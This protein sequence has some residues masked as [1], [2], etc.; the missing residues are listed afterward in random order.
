MSAKSKGFRS[1]Q[2]NCPYRFKCGCYVALSV[3]YYSDKVV[4]MQAGEHDLNSHTK[5]RG[6]LTVKQR[7]AV[8]RAARSAPLQ[9][10]RQIQDSMLDCSPGKHIPYDRRHQNAVGRLVRKTRKEVMGKRIPG[11]GVD[12]SEGSM[13]RLAESLSLAKFLERHNDP[14]DVF[15]LGEHQPVCLGHQFE[16]GVTFLCLSTPHLLNNMARAENCGWQKVGHFDGAF[17]WCKKDFG[18]IG[19]GMNSM[20]A[21]FNPVSLSIVNS[22]SKMASESAYDATCA[23]LHM[24]YN[25]AVLCHDAACGFCTRRCRAESEEEGGTT[26]A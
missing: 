8:K 13:N 4:L 18:M 19:F 21:H 2:Y 17:N 26:I 20:G 15:H 9:V 5:K 25:E 12:G 22:E 10:G 3:K 16:G 24:L 7:G 1:E 11:V 6:F 14:D 23:G